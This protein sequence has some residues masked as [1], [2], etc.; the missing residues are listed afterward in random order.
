M[1]QKDKKRKNSLVTIFSFIMTGLPFL[2]CW[3]FCLIKEI[4]VSRLERDDLKKRIEKIE[5]LGKINQNFIKDVLRKKAIAC[6][7]S[8]LIA[9]YEK[10]YSSKEK[11]DCIHL[12]ILEDEKYGL[13]GLDAPLILAWLEKE[14]R[15]DPE[16]ISCAGAKGLTQ[17]M[18]YRAV[19]IFAA[20]GYPG[21]NR[22][23][24]F[25][26]VVN[27]AGGLYHLES[28]IK[29]WEWNGIKNKNLVLFYALHSYKWGSE[30][31]KELFNSDKRAERPAIEY[32]NWILNRREFWAERLKYCFENSIK[33]EVDKVE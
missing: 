21:Y 22:E 16:A 28:L 33:S 9:G 23:L 14:S 18:D 5:K 6:C 3:N 29:F 20:M 27:L 4:K 32:V 15:G 24:I 12:I 11:Q 8:G 25:D 10:K 1:Q 2:A 13:K 26:P 30:N 19:N 31:T 17:L 7:F